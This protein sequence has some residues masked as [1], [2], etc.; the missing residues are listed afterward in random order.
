MQKT[1]SRLLRNNWLKSLMKH[2]GFGLL[3]RHHMH[4]M[5]MNMMVVKMEPMVW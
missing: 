2:Q 5:D 3:V 4:N 1:V